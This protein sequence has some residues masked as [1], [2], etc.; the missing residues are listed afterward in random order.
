MMATS[1]FPHKGEAASADSSLPSIGFCEPT[2]FEP[3]VV[4]L[5]STIYSIGGN[6]PV[7]AEVTGP[8]NSEEY[9]TDFGEDMAGI[10][11]VPSITDTPRRRP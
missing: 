3:V 4:Q 11:A 2:G 9:I 7:R 5:Y 1:I 6:H 8:W 10:A